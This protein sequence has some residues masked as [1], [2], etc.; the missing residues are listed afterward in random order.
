MTI[1]EVKSHGT[2][3]KLKDPLSLN[4]LGKEVFGLT[5]ITVK[6]AV[7]K[8]KVELTPQVH[9]NPNIPPTLVMNETDIPVLIRRFQSIIR[10]DGVP[11]HPWA[12]GIETNSNP[13][14]FTNKKGRRI[15]VEL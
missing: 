7:R 3:T 10:S 1:F 5:P 14:E 9:S 12:I 15:R 2:R 6:L 13:L 4:R 8:A 11:F